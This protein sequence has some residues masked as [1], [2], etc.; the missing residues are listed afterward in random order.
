MTVA[1]LTP[2][3]VSASL[4]YFVPDPTSDEPPHVYI[5]DPPA[6]KK[7]DNIAREPHDVVIRDARGKEKEHDL[8]LDTSGFQFVKHVSEEKEFEDEARIKD[9]YYKETEEL[10][11]RETGAKR[12]FVFDHTLR[13]TEPNYASPTGKLIRG[14]AEHVHIDQREDTAIARVHRHLPDE[15]ERLL[16][17]RFRIINVWRPIHHPVA[18]KP[19]AVADFRSV[20]AEHDLVPIRFIWPDERVAGNFHVRYNPNH[21]WY[22]LSDQTPEEVT[23]IKCYDSEEGTARFTPHTAFL[24]RTSPKDAP[25]RE[26]IEVRCLVFDL[27]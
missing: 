10:V 9:A 13:R 26:S 4:N 1:V 17:G 25:H 7:K 5:Q 11:K 3:D 6:G 27:E 15:A 2:H 14:A 12:V 16:K 22:Y 24:D 23:L 8:S 21:K 19:L 20:D 18:H